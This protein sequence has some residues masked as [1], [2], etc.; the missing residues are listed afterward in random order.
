[1]SIDYHLYAFIESGSRMR[2]EYSKDRWGYWYV[3][4]F[5]GFNP[6]YSHPEPSPAGIG[7]AVQMF[8]YCCRVSS[9]I[10]S[11]DVGSIV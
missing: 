9:G 2:H 1:M 4:L 7:I 5:Y 3:Y 10:R 6:Q 11:A 8:M